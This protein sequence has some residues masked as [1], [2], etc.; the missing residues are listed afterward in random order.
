MLAL[1][2]GAVALR[3]AGRDPARDV[4]VDA[5]KPRSFLATVLL[6][7]VERGRALGGAVGLRLTGSPA[8]SASVLRTF[9]AG[10]GTGVV[11]ILSGSRDG[12]RN[13]LQLEGLCFALVIG[14][15][16]P[17]RA[18]MLPFCSSARGRGGDEIWGRREA[19][20]G[21]AEA[22]LRS[23]VYGQ[24]SHTGTWTI[25]ESAEHTTSS[26]LN[27]YLLVWLVVKERTIPTEHATSQSKT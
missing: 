14:G 6:A 23:C 2:E 20:F 3:E 18:F 15:G 26:M 13:D 12:G 7:L 8:L 22:F 25:V 10:S 27:L 1:K 4:D 16:I 9:V 5:E 21:R 17:L 11:N 19:G 24:L